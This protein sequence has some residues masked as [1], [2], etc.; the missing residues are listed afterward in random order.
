MWHRRWLMLVCAA[1]LAAVAPSCRKHSG[2]AAEGS[3]SPETCMTCGTSPAPAARSGEASAAARKEYPVARTDEQWQDQLTPLQYHVTRQKGTE[4][5]FTGQYWKTK[6]PGVYRCVCC[7]QTLFDSETK[8]DSGTGWP[9][10][11]GPVDPG[12]VAEQADD[13]HGMQRTEVVC[14]RCGAHLGHVFADGPRPT[15]LRYCINS[16]ALDLAPRETPQEGTAE[17]E[18]APRGGPPHPPPSDT[19][20]D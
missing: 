13:S 18:T 16:A 9:S 12:H 1:A 19:E 14:S 17:R 5:S 2:E 3:A 10:F 20:A 8:F 4:Q 15:G 6:T 7:G 11:H